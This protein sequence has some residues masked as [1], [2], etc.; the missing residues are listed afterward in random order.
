MSGIAPST[1][2]AMVTIPTS[3]RAAAISSRIASPAKSPSIAGPRGQAQTLERLGATILRVDEI[4]FEVRGQHS[5][6]AGGT[7][8]SRRPDRPEHGP[9]RLGRAGDRR[10]AERRHAVAR[11]PRGD[12]RDG[13]ATVERIGPF[14][15]VDVHVDK[16]R[17][18]RVLTQ[19][20]VEIAGRPRRRF[21]QHVDDAIT[22]DDDG[23][24]AD[25]PIGQDDVGVSEKNHGRWSCP[26]RAC[27]PRAA[28]ARRSRRGRARG[29]RFSEAC[30]TT[31]RRGPKTR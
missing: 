29:R 4:A 3:G 23:R 25:Q 20:E 18:D 8:E 16:A 9:Q 7:V 22:V 10:R 27:G 19:V 2:G 30:A 13:V 24:R 11:Q 28:V 21:P 12:A 1:S 14:D 26:R 31:A 6:R 5:R 15:A 17:D